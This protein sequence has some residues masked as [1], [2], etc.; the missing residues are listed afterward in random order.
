VWDVALTSS[1]RVAALGVGGT[2]QAVRP[3]S[4]RG[5]GPGVVK[6]A[7][8]ASSAVRDL[9]RG[10]PRSGRLVARFPRC[11]YVDVDGRL[12]AVEAADGLRLPCAVTLAV[13]A[14]QRPLAG[15]APGDTVTAGDRRLVVGDLVIEV[16]R[17]WAPARPRDAVAPVPSSVGAQVG[18][19]EPGWDRFV[20]G[21]LGLGPGLTPTGD[22][23]LAGLLVG[24]S[25][26]PDLRDPLAATVQR[27]APARTT[28]LSAELLRLAAAGLAAPAVVAVAD[29]LAGHGGDD[30]LPD[31]MP[32]LLAVG[33]TSGR[34]LAQGLLLAARTASRTHAAAA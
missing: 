27:H 24:L 11:A 6:L 20:L 26:R 25:A 17:W 34:A 29:A 32:A 31:A 10:P 7:G 15:L 12:V 16:G 8:A 2:R 1:D 9:V 19:P 21:L 28:W 33:H 5:Y 3:L 30:A 18:A 14:R 4:V 22:D 23:L 13:P